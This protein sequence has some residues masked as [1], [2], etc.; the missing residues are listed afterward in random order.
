MMPARQA[1]SLDGTAA[2]RHLGGPLCVIASVPRVA[3]RRYNKALIEWHN[4]T[5]K[6]DDV[7][8]VGSYLEAWKAAFI[9]ISEKPLLG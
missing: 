5:E 9:S 2:A 8:N 3:E 6:G 1:L 7:N 4:H